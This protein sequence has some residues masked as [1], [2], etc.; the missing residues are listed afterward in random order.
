MTKQRENGAL[1]R[2]VPMVIAGLMLGAA[3]G[4]ATADAPSSSAPSAQ[5]NRF[6]S[7]P[8]A[9]DTSQRSSGGS[10]SGGGDSLPNTAPSAQQN[11]FNSEPGANTYE[12]PSGG[13]NSGAGDSM[14]NTAP[15][16]APR[17]QQNRFN[18]E[19]GR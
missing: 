7:E 14:P 3:F 4:T 13:S 5:Q 10:E 6:N 15:S 1:K 19:P 11:R 9:G 16:T 8:G 18:S 17:A 12:R 2:S